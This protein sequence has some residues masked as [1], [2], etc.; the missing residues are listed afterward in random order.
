M[1]T[2]LARV[3]IS[4]PRR[5]VDVALPERVPLAELLP[6]VLRHAGEDLAD[7]GERHGGWVLRRVDGATLEVGRGLHAQ[8]VRDG[9]VLHLS[10]ALD[11]WPELEYDD[12]VEAVAEGARRRGGVW[13]ASTT[14]A[15]ALGAAGI[16]LSAGLLTLLAGPVRGGGPARGGGGAGW[17]GLGLAV[18]LLLAATVASRAYR[19]RPAAVVLGGFAMAYAFIGAA[20]LVVGAH[21]AGPLP[22]LRW[23]AGPELLAGSIATLA[24]AALCVA[25][26]ATGSRVFP[27][28]VTAGV[29]GALAA[30]TGL[31]TDPAAGA[32]VLLAVLLCG[33]SLLPG[34]AIHLGRM[35][36]PPDTLPDESAG[37][38]F[39]LDAIRR[40]P[41]REAVFAAV[42]RTDELL[43]GLLLG[44]AV[45]VAGAAAVL[46]ATGGPAARLLLA[47][48]AAVLLLRSRLFRARRLR[49]PLIAGGL[50]ALAALGAD[51]L[52]RVGSDVLPVAAAACVLLALAVV[53]AGTIWSQRPAGPLSARVAHLFELLVTAAVIPVACAV[54]GL[55][56]AV[57]GISL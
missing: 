20:A 22:A 36:V 54:A 41:D 45:L 29:L 21:P 11:D 31:A 5:R 51:L 4:T 30:L 46:A 35:P 6:E 43:A 14:R 53:P 44:H 27:A 33:V 7:T 15:A 55:Y 1:R 40:R 38:G 32:A 34:L 26:A 48:T 47:V 13:T 39:A 17:T 9:E 18:V 2:G 49:L 50:A 37:E 3:T 12:V 16:A 42:R 28:G 10:P 23:L 25:G 8:G 52:G 56:T 57:S 19:M 24:T